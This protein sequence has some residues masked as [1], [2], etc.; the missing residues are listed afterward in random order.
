MRILSESPTGVRN[1]LIHPQF[2]PVAA[3][4][5]PAERALVRVDVPGRLSPVLVA[6]PAPDPDPSAAGAPAGWTVRQL[7]DLLF[8]GVLGV[9]VGGRLGQVLFY[10]PAYYLEHPLQILA[11]WRGGMSFHGGFLGVLI[12]MWLYARKSGRAGSNHRFH[13]PAGAA[14]PRRRTHRQLHQWRAVGARG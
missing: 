8:Y 3:F 11:V 1:V 9:I 7:D 2:D 6:R 5:R 10:E 4:A 14:R 13:C 12:A